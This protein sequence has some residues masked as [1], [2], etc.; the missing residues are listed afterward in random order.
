[1]GE[2]RR[3]GSRPRSLPDRRRRTLL[4]ENG[5]I[6]TGVYVVEHSVSKNPRHGVW[7]MK[8]MHVGGYWFT[9]RDRDNPEGPRT[10]Q[11]AGYNIVR[12][13][14][15]S[16]LTLADFRA[17]LSSRHLSAGHVVKP[18]R[19]N[20]PNRIELA[21]C[22]WVQVTLFKRRLRAMWPDPPLN[23]VGTPRGWTPPPRKPRRGA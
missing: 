16:T 9:V 17:P 5:L 21:P 10:V 1:M 4:H 15:T 8:A 18:P 20:S 6:E 13:I 14:K 7:R 23:E 19:P 12:L 11:E 2:K 22:H 3:D